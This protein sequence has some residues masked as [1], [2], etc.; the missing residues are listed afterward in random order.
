MVTG[1]TNSCSKRK[2]PID[3]F[4]AVEAVLL[5]ELCGDMNVFASEKV[6]RCV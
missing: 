6:I 4:E 5:I 3:E 1:S 2:E